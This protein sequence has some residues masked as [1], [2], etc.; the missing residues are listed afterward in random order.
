MLN[1]LKKQYKIDCLRGAVEAPIPEKNRST[2]LITGASTINLLRRTLVV[3]PIEMKHISSFVK[4][5]PRELLPGSSTR[6]LKLGAMGN[7]GTKAKIPLILPGK[8]ANI[9]AN[10]VDY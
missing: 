7:G 2:D 3:G 6:K 10:A 8:L 5:E 4:C 9:G 1:G